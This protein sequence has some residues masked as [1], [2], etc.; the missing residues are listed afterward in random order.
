MVRLSGRKMAVDG[1]HQ[2]PCRGQGGLIMVLPPDLRRRCY[3]E[4]RRHPWK[5]MPDG[6]NYY[7]ISLEMLL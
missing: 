1:N 4:D 6:I 7:K 3:E 5:L 2:R